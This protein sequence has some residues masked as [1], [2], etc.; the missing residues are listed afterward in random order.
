MRLL[1]AAVLASICA[2]AAAAPKVGEPA[3][4]FTATDSAG[5][6][7]HLAQLR[8][9]F[10]VLEWSND[11][12]PF[13]RKHYD[14]GNMQSLQK[15]ATAKGAEWLTVLSSAPGNQGYLDGAAADALTKTRGAAP[16]HVLLDPSGS[17][18]HLFEAKTTP[19][20]F[21]I[22]PK[23]TLVYMGGIDSIASTDVD[24][25][26]KATPYVKVALGEAMAGNKVS[27]PVTRPYGCSVK[28]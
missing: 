11:G 10:V 4:D 9:K 2:T 7:V 14:S 25:I 16:T 27:E 26:A 20:L 12:C 24:D 13:V 19:H 28:Y 6:P 21:I 22:D 1:A 3:P 8:G 5:K 23:G 18:G 15:Q 17:V